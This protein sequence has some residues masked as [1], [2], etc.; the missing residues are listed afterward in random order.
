MAKDGQTNLLKAFAQMRELEL[1]LFNDDFIDF[2]KSLRKFEVESILVGGYAVVLHGYH[3]TTG[4][5]DIWVK[6]TAENYARMQK[7]F[8]DFGLPLNAI[9]LTNFLA[10][11]ENDVF[12]FGRP[13]VAIDLLTK[14]KGLDFDQAAAH[15]GIRSDTPHPICIHHCFSSHRYYECTIVH[16]Q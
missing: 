11:E 12:T 7:S 8:A 13:P 4:D 3:R 9:S 6:P 14:V 2:L 1:G 15:I 5:M 16:L 10:I